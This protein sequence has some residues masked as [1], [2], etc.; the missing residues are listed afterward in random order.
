MQIKRKITAISYLFSVLL[1]LLAVIAVAL[2]F[3]DGNGQPGCQFDEELLV[4]DYRNNWDP[5]RFWRCET[6]NVNAV[7]VTCHEVVGEWGYLFDQTTRTCIPS[8]QWVWTDF[9]AP[10]SLAVVEETAN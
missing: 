6:L 8:A 9:I 5:T 2:A 10:L 7:A 3:S 4:K 1:I